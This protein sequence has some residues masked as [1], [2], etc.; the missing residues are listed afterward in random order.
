LLAC[1]IF[2]FS[3]SVSLGAIFLTSFLGAILSL[4]GAVCASA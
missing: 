4:G 3:A 1:L 2:F